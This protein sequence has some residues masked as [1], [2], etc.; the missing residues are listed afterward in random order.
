M[1]THP[2]SQLT[3]VHDPGERHDGGPDDYEHD[4]ETD[5]PD[6]GRHLG[7]TEGALHFGQL[8]PVV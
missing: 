6:I 7:A 2:V 3:T 8:G 4:G 1:R 5:G